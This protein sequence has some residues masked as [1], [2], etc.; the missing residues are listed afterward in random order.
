MRKTRSIIFSFFLF[1]TN[2]IQLSAQEHTVSSGNDATGAGGSVSYTIGQIDYVSATGGGGTITQG[3]QQPYEI[4]SISVEDE[5]GIDLS[6]VIY[7]NPTTEYV[8]L[9]ISNNN[10]VNVSY[11]L[12]DMHG[13][14]ISQQLVTDKIANIQMGSLSTG[15]YLLSV[16]NNDIEVKTFKIIKTNLP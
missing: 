11:S 12:L 16:Y 1:G 9:S 4:Y 2:L 10:L 14:I 7:P 15:I 5:Q 6:A 3:V 13:K 8:T